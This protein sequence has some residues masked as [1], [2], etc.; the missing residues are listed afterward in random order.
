[1]K[2]IF[3]DQDGKMC[4][5]CRTPLCAKHFPVHDCEDMDDGDEPSTLIYD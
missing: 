4:P 1:M 3:C 2:C 5:A